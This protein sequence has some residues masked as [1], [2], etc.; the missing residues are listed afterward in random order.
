MVDILD[1]L[2]ENQISYV[3]EDLSKKSPV[4][5][6]DIAP[7]VY[8]KDSA[9]LIR[10]VS[11]CRRCGVEF[12]LLGAMS[13]TIIA[14]VKNRLF[15]KTDYLSGFS[16]EKKSVTAEC[17]VRFS[18]LITEARKRGYCLLP[19]LIGIPGSVGGMIYSNAGAFG[20]EI[21]DGILFATVYDPISRETVRLSRSELNLDYRKSILSEGRFLLLSANFALTEKPTEQTDKII[22]E[23]VRKRREAQ[24]HDKATLGSVFKRPNGDYAARLIDKAGLRGYRIGGAAVSEKHAGFIV[25]LGFA[26]ADDFL[27]LV[28]LIKRTVF[29]KF[30]VLLEEEIEILR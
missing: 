26:T 24:P 17:G 25:N 22:R 19:S 1:F 29:E 20:M 4:K 12:Y 9:E 23:A 10:T 16:F 18:R 28:S 27:S 7:T 5:I 30:G 2:K 3:N 11:L 14:G 15:I 13:N 8:P 21:A 6:G